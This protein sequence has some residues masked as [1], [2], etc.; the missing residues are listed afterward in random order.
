MERTLR[1]TNARW[2]LG[3]P[4]ACVVSLAIR[5]RYAAWEDPYRHADLTDY[6]AYLTQAEHLLSH[7]SGPE[8]TFMPVGLSLWIALGRWL[9]LPPAWLPL[10]QV[11]AGVATVALVGIAARRLTA[12]DRAGSVAAWLAAAYPAF[13]YYQGFLFTETTCAA[14]VAVA[15]AVAAGGL[16][17]MRDQAIVGLALGTAAV[18]RTNLA[19][20]A[21]GWA[22]GALVARGVRGLPREPSARVLAW[23]A[24]PISAAVLRAS[25]L[26]GAPTG[27]ATNG[28]VNFLLAHSDWTELRLPYAGADAPNGLRVIH[29]FRNRRRAEEAVYHAHDPVFRERPL[30]AEA[31]R[32]ILRDPAREL[33]RLPAAWLDGMGLGREGYYPRVFRYSSGIDVDRWMERLRG[34]IGLAVVVPG[35]AWA[36]SRVRRKEPPP[37]PAE[38]GE[39][40]LL[41][42][43]A[44]AFVTFTLFLSEPRMRVPF[45]PAFLVAAVLAWTQ[46]V[47]RPRRDAVKESTSEESGPPLRV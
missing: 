17:R 38:P 37:K 5:L 2:W 31:W 3:I 13:I 12:S 36:L 23:S 6:Q 28:A 39:E 1:R 34:P 4:L 21:I 30:Y 10:W 8:D 32:S 42:A 20:V 22:A 27:P 11:G 9:R 29:F 46:L 35:G 18:W 43:I 15:V 7:T 44:T 25:L 26:V 41:A 19:L 33:R 45:D 24:L 40:L 47:R 14:L 16:S